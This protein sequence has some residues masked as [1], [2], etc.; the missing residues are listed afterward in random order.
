[1]NII[2]TII[3]IILLLA[4][5]YIFYRSQKRENYQSCIKK[6]PLYIKCIYSP[7]EKFLISDSNNTLFPGIPDSIHGNIIKYK[8]NSNKQKYERYYGPNYPQDQNYNPQNI[9]L[10]K[11]IICCLNNKGYMFIYDN[12]GKLFPSQPDNIQE[13][14]TFSLN[15]N[16]C[17]Y[18]YHFKCNHL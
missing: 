13:Y 10:P 12:E 5:L 9:E 16:F 18:E 8:F 3:I 4:I 2:F 1:M 17:K 6:P 15:H 14:Q 11:S 7:N